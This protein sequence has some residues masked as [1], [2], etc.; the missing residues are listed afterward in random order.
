MVAIHKGDT[1]EMSTQKVNELGSSIRKLS[2]EMVELCHCGFD[3]ME[4]KAKFDSELLSLINLALD[5][6]ETV[7]KLLGV[8]KEYEREVV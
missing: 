1:R 4:V 5:G 3:Y 2:N 8:I 6:E 7:T